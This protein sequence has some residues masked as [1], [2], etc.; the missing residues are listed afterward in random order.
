MM[1]LYK[2]TLYTEV[3]PGLYR[4]VFMLQ[5]MMITETV[6]RNEVAFVLKCLSLK[7]AAQMGPPCGKSVQIFTEALVALSDLNAQY[8]SL[9]VHIC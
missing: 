8:P 9:C 4:K 1:G 5:L 6:Q 2:C 3:R 7:V